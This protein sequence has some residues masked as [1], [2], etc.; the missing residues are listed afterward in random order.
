V[1]EPTPP[2]SRVTDASARDGELE[3]VITDLCDEQVVLLGEADHGDG[4]TWARKAEI[5]RA[6]VETCAFDTL[7]VEGGIYD[8]LALEQRYAAGTADVTD[9]T[10]AVGA[11]WSGAAEAQPWIAYLDGAA[12]AGTLR[13]GGL[14]DQL[15]STAYYA[16]RELPAVLAASLSGPRRS[17]CESTITRHTTWAYDEAHPYSPQSHAE[18]VG[19]LEEIVRALGSKASAP[20]HRVMATSLLRA[21]SREFGM[22][23]LAVTNARDASMFDNF[24]W[25][26]RRRGKAGKL[27]VWCATIHAAK[28][29]AEIDSL[30]GLTP[31]GQ[32]I[33]RVYGDRAAAVG[34][35]A[36]AGAS[37]SRGRELRELGAAP[38]DSLEAR[39]GESALR[40]LDA[41]ALAALGTIEARP[42]GH[43]FHRARWDR[44]LD[45]LVV[46][47]RED[48]AHHGGAG[49]GR[50][51]AP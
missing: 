34:F 8:F 23:G 44:I 36:R 11:V 38:P 10:N 30:R 12:R 21:V 1:Q 13:V 2:A 41:T 45:G 43:V 31:L 28:D 29:L 9:M 19:C 16:Q 7:L 26:R 48:P 25:H 33:H 4:R 14:D 3:R 17:A 35:T 42:L 24:E 40:Y 6:L 32:H 47:D 5:V 49:G 46:L 20:E 37:Q 27:I 39:A 51:P 50:A 22:D 15:H 18:L